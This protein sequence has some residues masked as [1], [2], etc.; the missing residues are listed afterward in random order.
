ML[1]KVHPSSQSEYKGAHILACQHLIDS[2]HRCVTK[3]SVDSL[4]VLLI[5]FRP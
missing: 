2:L 5:L 1:N 4:D 3:D